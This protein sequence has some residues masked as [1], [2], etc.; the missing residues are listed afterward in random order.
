MLPSLR[1]FCDTVVPRY[2]VRIDTRL[3]P[4]ILI[5]RWGK[6]NP[7]ER[8]YWPHHSTTLCTKLLTDYK[9]FDP[10]IFSC[11][12]YTIFA[13]LARKDICRFMYT[14]SNIY[15]SLTALGIRNALQSVECP[16]SLHA[17]LLSTLRYPYNTP[18]H[19]RNTFLALYLVQG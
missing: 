11:T 13:R 14:F 7:W 18:E 9:E 12:Y 10:E 17:A 5:F 1:Y 16:I 6:G 4:F 19:R 2:H 3:S 8:G 15:R